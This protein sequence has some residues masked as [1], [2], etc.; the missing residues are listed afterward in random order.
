MSS[1]KR[2]MDQRVWNNL[3]AS[4]WLPS[5]LSQASSSS[6]YS[7]KRTCRAAKVALLL[8]ALARI[9]AGVHLS[10]ATRCQL[11]RKRMRHSKKLVLGI[12]QACETRVFAARDFTR[13]LCNGSVTGVVA[14]LTSWIIMIL[15]SAVVLQCST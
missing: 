14:Y 5:A 8:A 7:P 11:Q 9:A 2:R 13:D 12:Y 15:L 10:M 4:M 6:M 1:P 3:G